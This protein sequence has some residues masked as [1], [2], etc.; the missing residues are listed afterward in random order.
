MND[1]LN[2]RYAITGILGAGSTS[3][4]Y[5]A[6]DTLRSE[7]GEVAIKQYHFDEAFPAAEM[8]HLSSFSHPG[9]PHVYEAFY[10]SGCWHLVMDYVD[11]ETL[12]RVRQE[13]SAGKLPCGEVALIGLQLAS[14]LDHVHEQGLVYRDLNPANILRT[15]AGKL[16]LVDFGSVSP[17]NDTSSSYGWSPYT[18]PE[19]RIAYEMIDDR[20]DIYALGIILFQLLF[21]HCHVEDARTET[22]EERALL[23]AILKMV[24]WRPSA[25]L[26]TMLH[27]MR[28]LLKVGG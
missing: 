7:R 17:E 24:S 26:P 13:A 15:D 27:V 2:T 12:E 6:F 25:R 5:R 4:V 1:L 20:A 23:S 19:Q 16:F 14:I 28:E 10:S 22:P 21:G 9:I 11:G 18:A 8:Q 3:A